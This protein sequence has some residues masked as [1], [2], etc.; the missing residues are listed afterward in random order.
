M[1]SAIAFLL[2]L[3]H[4]H[5][6]YD[7]VKLFTY[8]H[9]KICKLLESFYLEESGQL[10]FI[11]SQENQTESYNR[12]YRY[13]DPGKSVRRKLDMKMDECFIKV[14]YTELIEMSDV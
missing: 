13:F 6:R 8:F 7:W 1:C 10:L 12:H 5:F 3:L 11:F 9:I 4:R 14:H 2:H